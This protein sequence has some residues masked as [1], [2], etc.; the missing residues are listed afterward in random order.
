MRSRF[1]VVLALV[2]LCLVACDVRVLREDSGSGD[3]SDIDVEQVRIRQSDQ[4]PPHS[5]ISEMVERVLPSVVN[6][7]VEAL[8]FDAFG[9]Q[10]EAKGEGSG[11]VIDPNGVILTNNHVVRDAVSVRVVFNDGRGPVDG[12]VIR[13]IPDRDLAI[14]K[15]PASGLDAMTIGHSDRLKLGDSVVAVGFPLGLG[16]PTVTQGIVSGLDRDIQVAEGAGSLKLRGLLQTDAAI[17]PGNSGGALVDLNGQLVGINTAAAQ[18]STAENV[19]FAIAIDKALPVITG[20]LADPEKALPWLGV[21]VAPT[22]PQIKEELGLPADLEGAAV[23]G[24]FPDSP[25]E[26]AGIRPFSDGPDGEVIVAIEREEITSSED[27]TDTLSRYRPGDVITLELY[28]DGETRTL[29]V[30]LA[31]RPATFPTPRG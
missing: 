31:R 29:D 21:Q 15:V 22:E 9:N 6:V 5:S 4:A 7:K 19:G 24:V 25:A 18:A 26:D 10:S 16:G 3:G 30:E 2:A 12:T 14:I 1:V 23:V 17:N 8:S 11:V 27:L 13:T 28:S 20:A